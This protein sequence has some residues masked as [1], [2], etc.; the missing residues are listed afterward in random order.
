MPA[1]IYQRPG[2]SW[3]LYIRPD[4]GSGI[5]KLE[6]TPPPLLDGRTPDDPDYH[7]DCYEK[8]VRND[9]IHPVAIIPH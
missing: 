5:Y 7:W 1:I 6:F 9:H 2:D 4:G 8:L 3:D